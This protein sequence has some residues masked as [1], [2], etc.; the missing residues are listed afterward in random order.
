MVPS[1]LRTI[2]FKN[3]KNF[4][5]TSLKE[6]M[7]SKLENKRVRDDNLDDVDDLI[8]LLRKTKSQWSNSIINYEYMT[9]EEMIDY[10]AYQ[11]K[12]QELRFK[13]LLKKAKEQG[14]KAKI[15]KG[16]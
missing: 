9:E 15:Y 13:Y 11:I 3:I 2:D 1:I 14:V 6:F 10:Y 16:L 12:A 4:F 5:Q 7:K 8:N